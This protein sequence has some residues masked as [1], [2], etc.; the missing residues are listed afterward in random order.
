[1]KSASPTTS[2]ATQAHASMDKTL[3]LLQRCKARISELETTNSDLARTHSA[4]ARREARRTARPTAATNAPCSAY[5]TG[6]RHVHVAYVNTA[7]QRC[8]C[9]EQPLR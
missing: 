5:M 2:V 8:A 7:G 4:A 9:I 3:L 1:M 6:F